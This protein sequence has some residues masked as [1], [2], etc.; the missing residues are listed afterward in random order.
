[1]CTENRISQSTLSHNNNG[2]YLINCTDNSIYENN[3]FNNSLQA[4]D[5]G[6]NYWNNEYQGNYWSD[7]DT[8]TEGAW[9]NDSDGKI[10]TPYPIPNGDNQDQHPLTKPWKLEN[11]PPQITIT[12]PSMY[13]TV[14]DVISIVGTA[15]DQDGPIQ[16]VE[17][18]I[19]GTTWMT[20]TGTNSW[21]YS[22]DTHT[23]SND[24][25]FISARSYDG[26]QYST[27][28]VVT[29]TVHNMFTLFFD[30]LPAYGGNITLDPLDESYPPETRVTLTAIPAH[31]YYF[32]TWT[33][34]ISDTNS[35]VQVIMNT[36]KSITAHFKKIDQEYTLNVTIIPLSTGTVTLDPP[37]EK[38]NHGAIVQATALPESGYIFTNWG[39][40]SQSTRASIQIVVDGNKNIIAYFEAISSSNQ[41]P[42]AYFTFLADGLFVNFKDKSTDIDGTINSWTWEFGDENI[43]QQQF[44]THTYG[45]EG[46]YTV[47]LTVTDNF[48]GQNTYSVN[49]NVKKDT[50][51]L[52]GFE[53]VIFM[54]A[55]ILI[56]LIKKGS[57]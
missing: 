51:G 17:I 50:G 52:P 49:L 36:D 26:S 23:V 29:V 12:K 16:K 39:G 8:P 6:T 55:V 57:C 45:H 40:D 3:F 20:A 27:I 19:D 2:V 54:G 13:A 31:G 47:R 38:Y 56:Y 5:D 7:F 32:A 15:Y 34:D 28:Q 9:D 46:Q 53:G 10:D 48:G 11:H 1:M 14:Q 30:T 24:D 22:W 41:R 18:S 35:T 4:S 33:G 42:I 25:Y 21:T 43:S 44:P 37:R